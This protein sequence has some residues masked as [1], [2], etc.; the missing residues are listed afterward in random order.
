MKRLPLTALML[1]LCLTACGKKDDEAKA[2]AEEATKKTEEAVKAA[3]EAAKQ[4]VQPIA[5]PIT[6]APPE[7]TPKNP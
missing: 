2:K 5:V 1:G 7:P 3:G 6:T 4:A